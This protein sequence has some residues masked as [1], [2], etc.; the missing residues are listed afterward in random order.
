[1]YKVITCYLGKLA[2]PEPW[3]KNACV[4]ALDFWNN[5]ALLH[6]CEEI[7]AESKAYICPWGLTSL[8]I[9]RFILNSEKG[10]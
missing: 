4:N 3:D 10:N 9:C 6:G 5:Q 8:K 7:I 1:M 2:T